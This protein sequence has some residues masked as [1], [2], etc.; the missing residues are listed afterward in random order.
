MSTPV[1]CFH[2]TKEPNGY[3]SNWYP[4]HFELDE[5]RYSCVLQYL[6]Q[7]KALM[8]G[9]RNCAEQIMKTEDPAEMR[10]LGH[11]V[12]GYDNTIWTGA[13]Q[14]VAF[15]ALKAKFSQN[16][17]L[18]ERLLATGDAVLANCAAKDRIWGNGLAMDNPKR[19]D[20]P[21]W[22]GQNLLGFTLMLVRDDMRERFAGAEQKLPLLHAFA[23]RFRHAAETIGEQGI[24]FSISLEEMLTIGL[25]MDCGNS[26]HETYGMNPGDVRALQL[27]Y[28]QVDDPLV[29]GNAI[30]SEWRY[31]T[32]WANEG[33]DDAAVNWFV[34][35]AKR[36]VELIGDEPTYW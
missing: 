32:H 18:R 15:R 5:T 21:S 3:L 16:A 19:L 30:F 17:I 33:M 25:E 22:L 29:L 35:A 12:S 6:M 1:T 8:F 23:N 26:Y 4:S 2:L 20:I 36:L 27:R 31:Y 9:D 13:R 34:L 11:N 7:Q 14:T 28:D 10:K 24:I